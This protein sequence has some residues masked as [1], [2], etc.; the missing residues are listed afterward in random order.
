[1]TNPTDAKATANCT[2]SGWRVHLD[3]LTPGQIR[4]LEAWELLAQANLDNPAMRSTAAETAC[5]R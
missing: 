2:E 1:M 4:R 3:H 5:E